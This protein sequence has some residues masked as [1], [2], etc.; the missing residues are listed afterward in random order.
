[1]LLIMGKSLKCIKKKEEEEE[2]DDRRASVEFSSLRVCAFR[3]LWNVITVA[4]WIW[5]WRWWWHGFFLTLNEPK[6]NAKNSSITFEFHSIYGI[7]RY[8][9]WIKTNMTT[10]DDYLHWQKEHM[11]KKTEKKSK[12]YICL[13]MWHYFAISMSWDNIW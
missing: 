3:D 5:R 4:S 10:I 9:R 1:M 11:D 8:F 7:F 13:V 2:P 6:W 12:L